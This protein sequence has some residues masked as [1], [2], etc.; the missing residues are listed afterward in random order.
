[1]T[2]LAFG[3]HDLALVLASDGLWD[4]MDPPRVLHCLKNTARSPDLF[5]KRLLQES[6]DRGTND[7][8]SVVVVCLQDLA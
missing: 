6:L 1:M 2:S 4:V 8:T 5:A 7:N 3:S